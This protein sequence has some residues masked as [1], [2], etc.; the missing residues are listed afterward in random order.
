ME[1]FRSDSKCKARPEVINPPTPPDDVTVTL[2]LAEPCSADESTAVAVMRCAPAESET[3]MEAPWPMDPSTLEVQERALPMF[4][5]CGSVAVA[6]RVMG[7]WLVV[8]EAPVAGDVMVTTGGLPP[9]ALTYRCS[10]K[11]SICCRSV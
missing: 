1:T 10:K 5:S 8:N 7:I 4:P 6:V 2:M 9:D 3:V 11:S